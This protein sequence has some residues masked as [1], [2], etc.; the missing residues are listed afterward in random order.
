MLT[1]TVLEFFSANSDGKGGYMPAT[2]MLGVATGTI[3]N[4]GAVVPRGVAF[5]LQV[6]TNGLL[7]FDES[8]Y[9]VLHKRDT[10]EMKK[11]LSDFCKEKTKNKKAG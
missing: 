4:W 2:E 8:V 10:P 6:R 7:Q 1:K 11:M 3:S 9:P 5:E